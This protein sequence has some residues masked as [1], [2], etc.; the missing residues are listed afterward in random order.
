MGSSRPKHPTRQRC[1][2]EE[3]VYNICFWR[4]S[5]LRRCTS[6]YAVSLPS[7]K[8]TI[9]FST[10]YQTFVFRLCCSCDTR[11]I[12]SNPTPT[13]ISI[14][15][16]HLYMRIF[17]C[18]LSRYL[19]FYLF[20]FSLVYIFP[21]EFSA[22][23][24]WPPLPSIIFSLTTKQLPTQTSMIYQ[25]KNSTYLGIIFPNFI[26]YKYIFFWVFKK[27]YLRLIFFSSQTF[28]KCFIEFQL[29][30]ASGFVSQNSG[31]IQV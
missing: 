30:I 19:T 11:I 22:R 16:V 23:A 13:I 24:Y 27:K 26:Y 17:L 12:A 8:F 9:H 4:S 20:F 14:Y 5:T 29:N 21:F 28:R 31:I 2:C 7:T 3:Y 6:I 15:F 18:F 10:S 1:A 25:H